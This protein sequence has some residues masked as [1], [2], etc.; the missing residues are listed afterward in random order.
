M[1]STG[2]MQ[3][4]TPRSE[5]RDLCGNQESDAQL[6]EPPRVPLHHPVL[7]EVGRHNSFYSKVSNTFG[8]EARAQ[9]TH[10]H[11]HHHHQSSSS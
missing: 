1:L 5:D 8:L 6:T 10:H 11:H 9:N 2:P 3:A 7:L 4:L